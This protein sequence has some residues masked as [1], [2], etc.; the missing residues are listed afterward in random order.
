[1]RYLGAV[2]ISLPPPARA[3]HALLL[4]EMVARTAKNELR[5]LWRRRSADMKTVGKETHRVL[6]TNFLQLL[7]GGTPSSAQYW[8][9]AVAPALQRKFGVSPQVK[10]SSKN[11]AKQ[12]TI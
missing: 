1:M 12:H 11:S 2:L 3:A 4:T 7:F 5:E 9:R 10:K 6:A 8:Q